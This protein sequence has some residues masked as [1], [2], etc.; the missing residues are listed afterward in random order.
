MT[1]ISRAISNTV[2]FSPSRA[3][4]TFPQ[5]DLAGGGGSEGGTFTV[6]ANGDDGYATKQAMYAS[7]TSTWDSVT[8]S[9]TYVTMGNEEDEGQI[10]WWMGYFRFNSINVSQG[11]TIS[12]AYLKLAHHGSTMT[13][14]WKCAALD[15]DNQGQPSAS[16]MATSNWTSAVVNQSN[17]NAGMSS[18]DIWTSSDIK[19]VIQEIVDRSGWSSGNSIVVI[20]GMNTGSS[21]NYSQ[22]KSKEGSAPAQLIINV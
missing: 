17:I 11:A 15:K 6:A 5:M 4:E 14:T 1:R 10:T 20:L 9:G 21:T 3:I 8:T 2:S 19:T 12:S 16:D 13:G 22:K 18:G 7:S